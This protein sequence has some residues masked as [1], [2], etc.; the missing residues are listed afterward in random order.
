M[1]NVST[2]NINTQ[3]SVTLTEHGVEVFNKHLTYFG[4]PP[5][6]KT[7]GDVY[8]APLWDIMSIFGGSMFNGATKMAFVNNEIRIKEGS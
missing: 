7:Q 1:N 2:Y 3:C 4:L 8:T 6:N 5:S